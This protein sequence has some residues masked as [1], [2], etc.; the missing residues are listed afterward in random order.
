MS[1]SKATPPTPFL[2][3]GDSEALVRDLVRHFYAHMAAHEP[4]LARTHSLASNGTIA[5]RTQERFGDF[6]IE[7]L[8]GPARFTPENGHPR[9]RM[10]HAHVAIDSRMRDAWIRCMQAAMNEVG[11]SGDVRRFLDSRFLEVADFLRNRPD[12]GQRGNS[13][14]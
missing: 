13:M 12:P 9:L 14:P 10:R 1:D 2:M 11:V 3:M 4:D 5:P 7:W 8:G 6:L